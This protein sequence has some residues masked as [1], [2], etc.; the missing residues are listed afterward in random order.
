MRTGWQSPPVVGYL[1]KSP[2]RS[3]HTF[4][5]VEPEAR[6]VMDSRRLC[7]VILASALVTLEG[8]ATTVALPAIGRDLSASM[9]H[10]QWIVNAPLLALAALLLPAGTLAD[11]YGRGP[12]IVAGL[13]VFVAAT[14]WC[15]TAQSAAGV[16]AGRLAQGCGGA[17]L[18][19]ACLALIRDTYSDAA[20][21]TRVLGLWA[22]AT[23]A[24]S[25]AGPL[26]AGA[27]VDLWSW[28]GVFIPSA[29]VGVAALFLIG[30]AFRGWTG[31]STA[32]VPWKAT[33]SL[34]VLLGAT[35]YSL[36]HAQEMRG[37][38]LAASL[39]TGAI[40]GALLL[41]ERQR[42]VLFPRELVAARNCVSANAIT[43]ALYFGVFG[44]SFLLVLYVQ[45]VRQYS[46]S[47][48]AIVLLPS[49]VMLLLAGRF[50]GW[51]TRFGTRSMIVTGSVAAAAGIALFGI[52]AHPVPLWPHTMVGSGL[53]GLGISLTV[54][55]L[56]HA[57]VAA[58]P[59]A[60][61]G[62]ASGLNH[63]L[64]RIAG[65]VAVALLGSI[66]ASDGSGAVSAEGVQRA[67][68][69]CA[70]VVGFGGV[71]GSALLRDEEP[72]GLEA[73]DT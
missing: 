68:L 52:S 30:S 49:S 39:A 58:V 66:A 47:M 70:A 4:D 64:V 65:L 9:A 11:R 13:A 23:G 61:A 33:A 34:I 35:A 55:A 2:P 59:E 45:Q 15:A 36:M 5:A 6:P 27:F 67:M 28:R 1:E 19:P 21:R 57:A 25:A 73:R 10:L 29:L 22:A 54:A 8:T 44:L 56:T 42:D 46:A 38:Q 26:L 20:E 3:V 14:V 48:A 32:P 7:G 17:L 18:L 72:G 31:T 50:G 62:A 69:V 40:A 51:T 16:V 24:A 41:R 63:A 53:F 71:L 60:C 43:F 12:A 37:A